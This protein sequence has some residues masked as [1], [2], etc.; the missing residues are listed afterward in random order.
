[1]TNPGT[2][3]TPRADRGFKILFQEARL[4]ILEE[5]AG[6]GYGTGSAH[7]KPVPSC[8]SRAKAAVRAAG[9]C[10]KDAK[11]TWGVSLCPKME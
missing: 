7:S 6:S 5:P 1:M 4:L 3:N 9:P 8:H 2:M 10:Q 11:P